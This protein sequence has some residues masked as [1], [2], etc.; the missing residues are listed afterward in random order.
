ML[1]LFRFILSGSKI[2]SA[3]KLAPTRAK[4]DRNENGMGGKS[5]LNLGADASLHDLAAA[6][7]GATSPKGSPK[8][9]ALFGEEE[10]KKKYFL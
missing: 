9:G 4:K 2:I 8:F 3:K 5:N 10:V 6:L 7:V 1:Q